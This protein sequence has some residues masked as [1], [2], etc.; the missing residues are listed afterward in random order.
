MRRRLA[1]WR[2][3]ASTLIAAGV[4]ATVVGAGS[5]HQELVSSN[6]SVVHNE[7]AE[8][9]SDVGTQLTR[10][11]DLVVSA[12]QELGSGELD[13]SQFAAY[14]QQTDLQARYRGL[15]G[16]GYVA[17][18]PGDTLASFLEAQRVTD[19]SFS[20]QP[21]GVRAE[22]CVGTIAEFFKRVAHLPMVGYDFCSLPWLSS[23]LHASMRSGAESVV[24][25]SALGPKYHSDFVVIAPHYDSAATGP[26]ARARSITG[27]SAALIDG[28]ALLSSES[29]NDDNLLT[30][31]L[32]TTASP[33]ST[34]LI[35]SFE[36]PRNAPTAGVTTA[37][38]TSGPTWTVR[39]AVLG[40]F[41]GLDETWIGPVLFACG[42]LALLA[43]LAALGW[44]LAHARALAEARAQ[45]S[46]AAQARSERRFEDLAEASPLGILEASP[47]LDVTYV[48]GRMEEITGSP[49]ADLL[50]QGW[51]VCVHPEDR[52]SFLE[53]A[54]AAAAGG[55]ALS[56]QVR[57]LRPSGEVRWVRILT[58]RM[59][60]H[61]SSTAER[62]SR[63]ATRFVV[64]VEDTTDE[65]ALQ[66]ELR[67]QALHDSLT[68]LA[69]RALFVDRLQEAQSRAARAGSHVAVLFLD[70]DRFKF[71][72]DGLGHRVGDDLLCQIGARLNE[73]L[74]PQETLARLG[75][76]EFLI[77]LAE[78]VSVESAISLASR[79]QWCL[80]EP[81]VV[82]GKD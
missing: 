63:M 59:N 74:R 56:T 82:S 5:W 23:A 12:A 13:A 64:T 46:R 21:T 10:Y 33:R 19:P 4:V 17:D 44:L 28:R 58:S 11:D 69:N 22:Y 16:I 1:V 78:P 6:H 68:G 52:D 14:T 49:A 75:G 73:T 67:R 66:A 47:S 29:R 42:A 41:P 3:V 79:I 32:F 35:A 37:R 7:G 76:D 39:T 62:A 65:V 24:S 20:V 30:L 9:A 31:A 81:F 55:N 53:L 36:S 71:I 38:I 43:L 25:E 50:G 8:V 15:V 27:W 60:G 26:A 70:V 80:K 77:L 61:R 45:R 48:N 34:G 18:V 2:L 54:R 40:G 51:A 57:V 72:N